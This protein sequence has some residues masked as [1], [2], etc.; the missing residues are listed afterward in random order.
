MNQ[1]P[2]NTH[3]LENTHRRRDQKRETD[4]RQRKM[5]GRGGE[6]TVA[7]PRGERRKIKLSK[8]LPI[9]SFIP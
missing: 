5:E 1:N 2:F 8:T 6:E 3:L 9:P 7:E 4:E